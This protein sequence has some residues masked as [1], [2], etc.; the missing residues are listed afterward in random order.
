[1]PTVYL[2]LGSNLGDREAHLRA[3][4][5]RLNGPFL[6]ITGVSRIYETEPVGET[7]KPVPAYLN[8]V[9]RADTGLEPHA[10]LDYTQRIEQAG[11]RVQTFRWG[12]RAIDI[13]LLLYDTAIIDTE[14]LTVPHPRMFERA[15][16][17]VP[18]AEL[19]PELV[20][21]DNTTIQARL[22]APELQTQGLRLW[23]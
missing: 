14:R 7:L 23:R 1:M 12:P 18:L 20:F 19:A 4:L 2:S 5:E 13:D 8:C 3:A 17:L 10:L 11:G 15:F 22:S 6:H 16:A 9:A 21:P